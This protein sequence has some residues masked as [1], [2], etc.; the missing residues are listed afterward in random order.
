MAVNIRLTLRDS[1]GRPL[2]TREVTVRNF[3]AVGG[4][5][6]Q[7]AWALYGEA[8]RA[9]H[10]LVGTTLA[11]EEFEPDTAAVVA[12]ARAIQRRKP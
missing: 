11:V 10:D 12:R 6:G 5:I 8:H 7:A 9:G 3:A 1:K 4:E 2:A